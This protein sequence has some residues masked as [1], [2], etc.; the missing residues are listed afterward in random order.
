MNWHGLFW[1]D[2][3]ASFLLEISFRTVIMFFVI[4][5]S[6]KIL[7]KRG[8]KQLSVFEL[9]IIISLGSAAGDPMFYREVGILSALGVFVVIIICYKLITHF[10][11]KYKVLEKVLEG[12]PIYLI[13]DGVFSLHNFNKEALGYDEFFSEMRQKGVSHLGQIDIAILEISGEI[14]L[15]FYDDKDVL[16]GLPILP[17]LYN[18]SII[19]ITKEHFYSCYFCGKTEMIIPKKEHICPNCNHKKW[20]KSINSLRVT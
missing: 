17:S 12:E 19:E 4:L 11:F 1:G 10:V 16:Y 18:N 15:Y 6:L 20:V 2:S 8:V 3:D 9:V 13:E 14:S 7:G 5:F